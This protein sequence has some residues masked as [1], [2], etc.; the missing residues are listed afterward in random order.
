MG[1]DENTLNNLNPELAFP[2]P[3]TQCSRTEIV[4]NEYN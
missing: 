4:A 3:A 1:R 2:I